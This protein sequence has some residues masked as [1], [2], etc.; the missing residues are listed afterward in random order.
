MKVS[1][2]SVY[3]PQ[4]NKAVERANALIFEATKKI[5]KGEKK[6][7]WE[8]SCLGLYGATTQQFVEPPTSPLS[9]YCSELRQCYHNKSSTKVCAQ[10]WRY[11]HALAKQRRRIYW[12]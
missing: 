10:Q 6:G 7:K 11:Y 4:S 2:T 5:L 12:N 9:S 3:H 1:C 8:D